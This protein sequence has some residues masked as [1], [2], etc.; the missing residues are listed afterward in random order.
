MKHVRAMAFM[1]AVYDQAFG[2]VDWPGGDEYGDLLATISNNFGLLISTL[3]P[4]TEGELR[5]FEAVLDDYEATPMADEPQAELESRMRAMIARKEAEFEARER[6][7]VV[8]AQA[9]IAR[10]EAMGW[11][12]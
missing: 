4:E 8:H 9:V 6:A 12:P 1:C 3:E 2:G 10:A 7:G 5:V 11:M